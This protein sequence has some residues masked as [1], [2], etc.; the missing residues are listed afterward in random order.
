MKS[1]LDREGTN[2]DLGSDNRRYNHG[3]DPLHTP[4]FKLKDT[5]HRIALHAVSEGIVPSTLSVA[6]GDPAYPAP[7]VSGRVYEFFYGFATTFA[8][9]QRHQDTHN[10]SMIDQAWR[11]QKMHMAWAADAVD[12]AE[13][14]LAAL[15]KIGLSLGVSRAD[16][17]KQLTLDIV[18]QGYGDPQGELI[19]RAV[20]A[21]HLN[22]RVFGTGETNTFT[23]DTIVLTNGAGEG[24]GA[25]INGLCAQNYLRPG[26][27][28]A[29]V[30][31]LYA[32]YQEICQRQG[33]NLLLVNCFAENNYVPSRLERAQFE[34]FAEQTPFKV[35]IVVE[36]SNP[37]GRHL[38]LTVCTWLAGLARRHG[39]I[40][41]V[42]AVYQELLDN[43]TNR[44]HLLHV[45]P[46]QTIIVYSL[47]KAYCQTGSRVGAVAYVSGSEQWLSQR[48]AV[49]TALCQVLVA[50][51]DSNGGPT[52][53]VT[54]VPP[55]QQWKAVLHLL[56]GQQHLEDWRC[57]LGRRYT[58]F[59]QALGLDTPEG[60][61]VAIV[62]YY[63]L[64]GLDELATLYATHEPAYQSLLID[65]RQG[66][67]TPGIVLEA[68]AKKGVELLYAARFYPG[69]ELKYQWMVRISVA[70]QPIYVL[71][72]VA[73]RM[74]HVLLD[75][76]LKSNQN[77]EQAA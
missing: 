3:L 21:D 29:M 26:D 16:L 15:V 23:S 17:L 28:V 48:L 8:E 44:P 19:P 41:L 68:M 71:Q 37:T 14:V 22:K 20:F 46:E 61:G 9:L 1:R 27:T 12:A 74:K 40:V 72:E 43:P 65:M 54:M 30:A 66:V 7:A 53:H 32:P 47:S 39:A 5:I 38:D 64:L 69:L 11:T 50:A 76:A 59:H 75:L 42:D 10:E 4:P 49:T 56:L 36:P 24:L 13:Q 2:K 34:I 6:R 73:A 25:I 62:P 60:V 57:E 51:K 70:N 77:A 58:A 67:V 52:A 18:G 31:P 63:I 33:L 55:A 35:L 45:L